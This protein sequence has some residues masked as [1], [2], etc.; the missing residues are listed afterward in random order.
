M[1]RRRVLVTLES[2]ATYGYSKN[3]ML[4][5]REFPEL[6]LMTMVTGMHLIPEL[7]NSIDLIREDGFPVSATVTMQGGDKSR[8]AWSKALGRAIAGYAEAY[9]ELAPD[10]ILLSGDRIET[11]GCCVAA[12][13]MGIPLAHIQAGDK[14][15]HIDDSAR[16]AIGKFAHIHLASCEDSAKRLRAMGEQEFRIFNVGAP[17][18]DNIV[19]HD[20]RQKSIVVGGRK[21]DLI[22]PYILMVQHSVM[23][24][25][26]EAGHQATATLNACARMGIPVFII[27]PNSDIGY[28]QI[29]N[30]IDEQADNGRFIILENVERDAYLALLANCVVL[31]GNSS[32]GILE[33]PSFCVPVVNIGNRQRGRPQ[34]A[35]ILNC[36]YETNDIEQTIRLALHD[37]DFKARCH[38]AVNPYGDGRSSRRICEI[39]RDI[40]LD[41]RLID[42]ECTY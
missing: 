40:P 26:E 33:A 28:T 27:Y 34:A 12:A 32:S 5:M 20:F 4:M 11:F 24:E 29:I 36:G 1:A 23:A 21:L 6:E 13:Y 37:P 9:E 41:K 25:M 17:Q 19:N 39:L 14:S 8:G 7:G 30:C 10:I 42:K 38:K 18:L 22:N 15:G 16:H 31:V 2:R 3:V 35:N